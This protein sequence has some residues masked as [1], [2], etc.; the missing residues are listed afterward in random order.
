MRFG[1]AGGGGGSEGIGTG[2]ERL[3]IGMPVS[4][5]ASLPCRP[6]TCPSSPMQD[7]V[8]AHVQRPPQEAGGP[9]RPER[10]QQDEL[11]Y[12]LLAEEV[13]MYHRAASRLAE[14]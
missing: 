12:A 7:E 9:S 6:T 2:K 4:V 8:P 5:G 11:P 1:I 14:L 13:L 10:A 3:Q